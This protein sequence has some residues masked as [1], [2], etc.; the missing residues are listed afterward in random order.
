VNTNGDIT[1]DDVE[2]TSL[3]YAIIR[4]SI[5]TVDIGTNIL[6]NVSIKSDTILTADT[7][8]IFLSSVKK[9]TLADFIKL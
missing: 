6:P 1:P 9:A 7:L 5:N 4:Y 2:L 3:S 8:S